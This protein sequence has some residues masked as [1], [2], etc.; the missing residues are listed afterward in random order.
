[1]LE[2]IGFVIILLGLILASWRWAVAAS[3]SKITVPASGGSFI[4]G[5]VGDNLNDIDL[6]RLTKSALVKYDPEGKI[7]AD[8]ASS[9]EISEDKLKYKFILGSSVSADEVVDVIGKNPIYLP[10][11]RVEKND[12][13][14]VTF[15]LPT[16]D[17]TFL[18]QMT[19]P[20]FAY[21]PYKIERKTK[22]EIRLV[23]DKNYHL[24]QP[25]LDKF[26]V[27][28]YSDINALQKAADKG[29][30]NGA[31]GL[32]R[33]P[34]KWQEKTITLNKR[35]ILFINTS[36]PNLK[37]LKIRQ[38]LLA[39]EKPNGVDSIDLLEVNGQGI[40]LEY[41]AL[42]KKLK[43]AGVELKIR[44]VSL[45]DAL[46][47]DLPKRNYDVLYLLVSEGL[48]RD[49]YMLWNSTQRSGDGQNFAELAD[50]D[51][52]VL[53]EQYRA[54]EDA[55]KKQKIA[56][57]I[58]ELVKNEAVAVEYKNVEMKYYI[59]PKIKG[60]AILPS[61]SSETDRFDLVNYWYINER[62]K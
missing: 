33:T 31:L 46:T 30:I 47:G 29:K 36:K 27:R 17:G 11:V 16:A 59:S 52:D 32:N 43:D 55:A 54:T 49:P 35:H 14:T 50:A 61:L 34:K 51:I 37:D 39:G 19:R 6:G 12:D 53:T 7:V 56:E 10:D 45:K 26:T 2:K 60:T 5:M 44:Q 25:Y 24:D 58:D 18:E 15:T 23:K 42:K 21:G 8:L 57:K 40:D 13:K 41:E 1:M 22:N 20:V 4:E 3:D 38:K 28:I 9:W 48:N 62:R